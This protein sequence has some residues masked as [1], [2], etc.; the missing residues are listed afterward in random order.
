MSSPFKNLAKLVNQATQTQDPAAEFIGMFNKTV[1]KMAEEDKKQPSRTFKPSSLG[2]CYRKVYFEVTG[3]P[4]DPDPII[5]PVMEGMAESGTDRHARIQET[6]MK[7]KKYG[8]DCEWIDVEQ[9]LKDNP[10]LGTVIVE[11]KGH[12]MKLRNTILNMSFMC[13]GIIKFKGVYYVLE[14]KTETSFK[15][16]GRTTPALKHTYQATAYSVALGIDRVM[17]I[18]ENRDTTAKRGFSVE[19]QQAEKE[20]KVFGYIETVNG[21]IEREQIPPMT[22]MKS[23]CN[24]CDFKQECAKW[25]KT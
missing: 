25:G 2:G 10:Q 8:F 17:F 23:E 20:E 9:Y 3:A 14:I 5:D 21:Y 18:Y 6:I 16:Q 7:M 1:I 22:E 13:D 4:I 24:Y 15:W 19:V 11:R 12:E